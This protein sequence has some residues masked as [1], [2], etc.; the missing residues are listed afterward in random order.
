MPVQYF[1]PMTPWLTSMP[2][3]SMTVQ[4]WA[5]ESLRNRVSGGSTMTSATTNASER[6]LGDE[7]GAPMVGDA[8]AARTAA[9]A[10]FEGRKLAMGL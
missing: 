5:L 6:S 4:P 3:P 8:V 2:S 7:L 9:M 10:I 1:T